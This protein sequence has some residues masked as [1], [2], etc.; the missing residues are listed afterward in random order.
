MCSTQKYLEAELWK[1]IKIKH[2]FTQINGHPKWVFEKINEEC[3][4]CGNLEMATKNICNITNDIT[5]TIHML[6]LP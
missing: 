2:E 1:K 3:K 5:N 4:L 6:V